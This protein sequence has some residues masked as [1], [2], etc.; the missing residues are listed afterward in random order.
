M[1][2]FGTEWLAECTRFLPA[3]MNEAELNSVTEPYDFSNE[4]LV[5]LDTSLRCS[6]CKDLINVPMFS[7]CSHSFCS[8]V[9]FQSNLNGSRLT[10]SHQCIR[11]SLLVSPTCPVCRA[12][13][14]DGQLKRNT[15]LSEI[16]EAYKLARSVPR[17]LRRSCLTLAT[18]ISY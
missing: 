1:I 17:L 2:I 15:M 13:V 10:H 6:I 11:E 12:A 16:V 8:M 4:H 18:E 3:N 14:S 5:S 9:I 7:P